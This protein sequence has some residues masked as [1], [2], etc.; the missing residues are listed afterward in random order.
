MASECARMD[1]RRLDGADLARGDDLGDGLVRGDCFTGLGLECFGD[2]GGGLVRG[3][4]FAGLGLE[5]FGDSGGGLVR[6]DCFAELGSECFGDSRG[7]LARCVDG[8]CDSG[9]GLV[10]VA[11]LSGTCRGGGFCF[12]RD[13]AGGGPLPDGIV[14]LSDGIVGMYPGPECSTRAISELINATASLYVVNSRVES[15]GNQSNR[16]TLSVIYT[17]NR[18]SSMFLRCLSINCILVPARFS[19][20]T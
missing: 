18:S 4:C 14:G 9:G 8:F 20:P 3:D 16:I 19:T 11:G 15:G 13:A 17:L 2:S 10:G 12:E 6:G 7:C 5:C 1:E